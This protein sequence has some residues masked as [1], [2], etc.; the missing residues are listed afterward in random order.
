MTK[1]EMWSWSWW[2]E[3]GMGNGRAVDKEREKRGQCRQLKKKI[4]IQ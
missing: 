2:G 3:D 4:K 1:R